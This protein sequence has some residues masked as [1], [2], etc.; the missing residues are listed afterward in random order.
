VGLADAVLTVEQEAAIDHGERL[1][2][3]RRAAV[4]LALRIHVVLE[5]GQLASH[6]PG[7]DPRLGHQALEDGG[8]PAVA[9]HDA[10][11]AV[12]RHALPARV[13]TDGA[14]HGRLF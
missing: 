2:E 11:D 13:V 8:A 12:G 7:R 9:P 6:I 5:G 4:G 14:R 10:L 3:R 1:D